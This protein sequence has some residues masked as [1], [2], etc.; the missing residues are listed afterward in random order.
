MSNS[1]PRGGLLSPADKV[2]I[3]YII[4]ISALVLIF[5][6]RLDLWRQLIIAHALAV[7]L[8]ALIAKWEQR[9][10]VKF[11]RAVTSSETGSDY[12]RRSGATIAAFIHGWYP[13][14]L[15]PITFTELR[16]LIPLIHPRDYD[17]ELAAIDYR[18][19]GVHPTIW[20][21]RCTWPPLTEAL[22]IAYATYYF[23]PITLGAV[24]WRKGWFDKYRFWVFIVAFGFYVSYLGYMAVPAIGPRFLPM[25]KDAQAFPLT[26][27]WLFDA[28]RATLDKA[29][30]ITR[31][32]FPSGH[33]ELTLLVLYYARKF[34]RQTFWWLLPPGSALIFST[35]YLRYHY[36]IDIIA[37]ALV[38]IAVVITAKPI[39]NALGGELHQG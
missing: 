20:L 23:L 32:C 14:A 18:I 37:G 1:P 39:Y 4:I 16:Y 33:T 22:Q 2:F 19:F 5:S 38:A 7:A 11:C 28:I 6:D 31:D 30:G 9:E 36:V 13:V 27:V 29:E 35:V 25:I 17:L 24:L 15:I 10:R 12:S 8:V 21:E 3:A 34:H 26:G